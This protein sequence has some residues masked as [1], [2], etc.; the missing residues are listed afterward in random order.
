MAARTHEPV[1]QAIGEG[2]RYMWIRPALLALFLV[3]TFVIM[4]G[5]SH[6]SLLPSFAANVLH[7]NST[8]YGYLLAASGVGALVGTLLLASMG[9]FQR[10]GVA[11]AITGVTFGG[12]IVLLSLSDKLAVALPIIA[13]VGFGNASFMTLAN[14]VVQTAVEDHVRGRITSVFMFSWGMFSFGGLLMGFLG[15]NLGV[16]NAL[17]IGGTVALL[18]VLVVFLGARS[19][20]AMMRRS[21]V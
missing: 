19:M 9:D 17:R 12:M 7:G 3:Q 11:L 1:L 21:N 10:K 16:P 5:Q 8:T 4:F 6:G 13:V 14:T 20:R 2:L 18:A 15:S